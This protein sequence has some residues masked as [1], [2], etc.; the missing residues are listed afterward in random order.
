[1]QQYNVEHLIIRIIDP[2]LVPSL[3]FIYYNIDE[4]SISHSK[5]PVTKWEYTLYSQPH[6]FVHV[7][8]ASKVH[9]EH[10]VKPYTVVAT[11]DCIGILA[12]PTQSHV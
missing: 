11:Y 12:F 2:P 10:T 5:I 6:E 9:N 3:Q 4:F 1:M 7:L 8:M